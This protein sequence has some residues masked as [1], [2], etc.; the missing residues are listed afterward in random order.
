MAGALLFVLLTGLG[1]NIAV[2]IPPFGVPMTLQTLMVVLAAMC[3]GPRVG[4]ASMGAYLL[5]GAIGAPLFSDW[6]SGWGVLVGATGGYLVGFIACQPVVTWFVRAK[7]GSVRGWLGLVL[8]VVAGHLVIFV[9]GVPWLYAVWSRVEPISMWDALY[10]GMIVFLPSMVVKCVLA[11]L[12]GRVAAPWA[13][14]RV[15]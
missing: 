4:M 3:L 13:S 14:R 5:A 12:I 10:G 6:S 9:F 7:D 2:P 11:V 15:W 8:G 1:A